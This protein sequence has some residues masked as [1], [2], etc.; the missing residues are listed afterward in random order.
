MR[1]A[2][3]SVLLILAGGSLLAAESAASDG[4]TEMDLLTSRTTAPELSPELVQALELD[5]PDWHK[6]GVTGPRIKIAA[7]TGRRSAEAALE[8]MNALSPDAPQND[9]DRAWLVLQ[10]G[11]AL[12][13]LGLD[14]EAKRVYEGLRALPRT[15]IQDRQ[16]LAALY[17]LGEEQHAGWCPSGGRLLVSKFDTRPAYPR[18]ASARGI[19]GWVRAMIDV[20]PDGSISFVSVQSSSLRVFEQP[21]VVW[22]KKQQWQLPSGVGP[23]RP[24]FAVMAVDFG[25]APDSKARFPRDAIAPDVE[26]TYRSVGAAIRVRAAAREAALAGAGATTAAAAEGP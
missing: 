16:V 21:V 2:I 14:A 11:A 23:G 17:G 26:F 22:L 25:V 19:E 6:K 24:C 7:D 8:A 3:L 12:H 13:A 18:A 20:Q 10:R 15:N 9:F 5:V 1:S 4:A